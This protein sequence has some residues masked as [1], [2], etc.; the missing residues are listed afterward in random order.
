RTPPAA[1]ATGGGRA[2]PTTIKMADGKTRTGILLAQGD[3]DATL[4]ENGK[5][6]LLSRDGDV[7][8]EKAIAPKADWLMYDGSV[9]GNRFSPI[10]QINTS[11]VKRVG[12]AWMFAMPTS[13]R[14][15]VTPTVV[16][17]IMYV[18]GW[19]EWYGLDETT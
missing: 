16:D 8:R 19:N 15:E 7:Y 12:P 10:E 18:G 14:L 9:T 17:G 4:L 2:P 3:I 11:N 5:Y 13:P 1:R 6:V